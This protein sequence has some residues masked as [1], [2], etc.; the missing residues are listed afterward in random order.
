MPRPNIV[1]LFTDQQQAATVHPDST[2]QTPTLDEFSASGTRFDRCYSPNPICSPSRAS[3]MTGVLPHVHGM[4]NVTH[5]VEPYGANFRTDL[6]TW[7]QRLQDAGYTNGYFGKWHVER[8]GDLDE[9]GFDDYGILRS[10]AFRSAFQ[11]YRA[12]LGLD[13][14]PDRSATAVRNP[15]VVQ[16]EGYDDYLLSG[17]IDEPVEGM[18]DHFIYSEGTEFIERAAERDGPWS[19][20]ISTYAPHDPYLS[21]T[22]FRDQ[23]DID[24]VERPPSFEDSLADNPDIYRRQQSVWDDL[25]WDEYAE[26][27]ASYYGYCSFL[28]WQVGRL[29]ETLR[30]TGQLDNTVIVYTSDHGDYAG[31]HGLFLKGVPAFEEAYRVPCLVRTPPAYPDGVVRDDIVQ[32]QDLAPT[33]VDLATGESFPPTSRLPP[34]SPHARGGENVTALEREP[35]FTATS[36]VPFLDDERPRDHTN[37]AF[38]EFHG[39]D[40]AWTQ[41]VYWRDEIKYVFNTFDD[42]E[43]YDLDGDPHELANLADDPDHE[44]TKKALA[45]RMWEIARETGDYQISELHYGM[46]RFAP[47]GPNG[48]DE[49]QSR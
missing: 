47:V 48:R 7:S 24:D 27:I 21:P 9:F 34:E 3:F 40:F 12:S 16:D 31:A 25:S 4:I 33:I 37:D 29:V 39:Q 32:L 14:E 2:C 17:Q 23:Y 26:A 8:S 1:V 13:P 30:E 20:V 43:L 6:E 44:A 49:P 22:T 5:G 35:S 38:A 15:I 10:A 46:H 41:R 36:L 42:D 11:D 19:T 45:E 28:D 18:V